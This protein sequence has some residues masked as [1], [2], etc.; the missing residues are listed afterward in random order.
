MI[1]VEEFSEGYLRRKEEEDEDEA[2]EE[3]AEMNRIGEE[4]IMGKKKRESYLS[5]TANC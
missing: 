5:E 1:G 3:V 4:W 2:D